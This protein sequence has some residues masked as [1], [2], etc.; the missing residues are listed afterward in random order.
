M[1][2]QDNPGQN[3][4][5]ELGARYLTFYTDGQLFGLPITEIVQITKMQEIV[6]LPEHPPYVKGVI[7]LRGQIIPVVDV[8][9]RFGKGEVPPGDRTCII[10]TH[11]GGSDFGLI[12]DAVDEVADIPAGQIAP[13]PRVRANGAD[14]YITGIARL[15][16]GGQKE[17]V[18]LLLH[19]GRVLGEAEALASAQEQ[20]A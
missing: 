11:V 1:K 19:A 16:A 6:E 5:E 13:P 3:D 17:R 2:Q 7:D 18:V 15:K 20:P 10:I 12:V 4:R 8:R 14:A 9:L